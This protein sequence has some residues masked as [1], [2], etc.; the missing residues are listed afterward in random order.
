MHRSSEYIHER[1][2]GQI[3]SGSIASYVLVPDSERRVLHLAHTWDTAQKLAHHYEFLVYSGEMAGVPV[4]ACS[5]GCGG[6]S[7]SIAVDE[8]AALGAT[9]FLRVGVTGTL[10]K[11]IAVGDLVI[12][13]AAVRMDKTSEHYVSVEYPAIADFEVTSAL[14]AAAQRLA[15][16]FHVGVGAT[17]SSFYAGKGTTCFGGYRHSAMDHIESD[18][19]AA[20]VLDW[21]TETATIFTLCSLYGLRAG[22]INAVVDDPKTG[23]YN[24]VGE[25]RAIETALEAIK[26]LAAWD[27]AKVASNKKHVL[28]QYPTAQAFG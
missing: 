27:K 21:D 17:A 2:G 6:R 13:S 22:R 12:A 19:R 18:L 10:Q 4:S 23:Y 3:E 15:H 28:P 24:P 26:I 16:P 8:M 9:T 11:S 14:V 7:T 5:T 25:E 20:N 1:M